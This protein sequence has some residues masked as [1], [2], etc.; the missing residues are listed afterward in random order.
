MY[1][2]SEKRNHFRQLTI[3]KGTNELH[4]WV[5]AMK[6]QGGANDVATAVASHSASPASEH[7]QN[8]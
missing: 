7:H 4:V 2:E 1:T 3:M 8:P 6:A 5:L